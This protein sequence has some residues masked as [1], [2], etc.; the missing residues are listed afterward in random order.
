MSGRIAAVGLAAAALLAAAGA[1]ASPACEAHVTLEPRRGFVGQ[2]ILHRRV[3]LHRADAEVEWTQPLRFPGFRVES[4]SPGLATRSELGGAPAVRIE[5][6][7]RLF[8]VRAGALA[9]PAGRLRCGDDEIE[10]TSPGFEARPWPEAGRPADFGGVVGAVA[11]DATA[12]AEVALGGS[13]R[14]HVTSRGAASLWNAAPRLRVEPAETEVFARPPR[15]R[16]GDAGAG[17]RVVRHDVFDLVPRRAGALRVAPVAI[18]YLDPAEA[19]YHVARTDPLE[20]RVRPASSPAAAET[21]ATAGAGRRSGRGRWLAAAALLVAALA[22]AVAAAR[23]LRA[24]RADPARAALREFDRAADPMSRAAAL[25]RALRARLAE[26]EHRPRLARRGPEPTGRA[27]QAG[28]EASPDAIA[29]ECR[30]ALAE[31]ERERFG[32]AGPG[33]GVEARLEAIRAL[34]VRARARR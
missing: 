31:L 21:P 22:T 29:D 12:E 3:V 32:G 14:V 10:V 17:L 24:A 27:T 2:P 28:L 11:L 30:R 6:P 15:I 16:V 18:A 7:T 8:A 26:R 20:I 23:R 25:E 9:L 4:T 33:A 34:V 5:V 19:R 1:G 13:V